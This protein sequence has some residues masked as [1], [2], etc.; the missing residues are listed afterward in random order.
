[1]RAGAQSRTKGSVPSFTPVQSGL[2][3]RKCACG[4]APGAD[5]EC[6][7]CKENRLQ[8]KVASARQ[9][10]AVPPLMHEVLRSP[11]R[12]LDEGTR[13]FLEPRFGHDFG[14]VRVHTDV[15]AAK[16][17]SA[18][19][20]LAYTVGQDVVFGAGRYEP[21][22]NEGRRLIAHE[23]THTLQ[24]RSGSQLSAS[25]VINEPGDRYEREADRISNWAVDG[26]RAAG[27]A[28]IPVIQAPPSPGPA[29]LARA[30]SSAMKS[31]LLKAGQPLTK[32]DKENATREAQ[33][34]PPTGTLKAFAEGPTFVLHDTAASSSAQRLQELQGLGRRSSGE[35]A[36]AYVP[37]DAPPV[38]AH[39]SLFSQR[40]PAATQYERIEDKLKQPDREKSYG[41]V[42]KATNP[43]YREAALDAVLAAQGS[44]PKEA[45][46]LRKEAIAQL[47]AGSGVRS[48]G[49]WAVED[50]CDVVAL[51]S[52]LPLV[53][54]AVFLAAS[55][56]TLADLEAACQDLSPVHKARKDR[57]SSSTNVE[58]VQP[59]GSDCWTTDAQVR[60]FNNKQVK[61]EKRIPG[62]AL[63]PLPTPPYSD[64][65]YQG[66]KRLYLQAALVAGQ[67][68][69]ITTHFKI[70]KKIGDH[71]DP[72]CFNLG[73]LYD[74]IRTALSHPEGAIY[75][76]IPNYDRG[77]GQNVWWVDRVCG[78]A[79]P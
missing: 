34:T 67:F 43:T 16:S 44:S 36:A 6:S 5:G 70:D 64:N 54:A 28:E 32:E 4:G 35:G 24:Q 71:C 56:V 58:M 49:A 39:P 31:D 9:A 29:L 51:L 38:L 65:Q 72:R 69:Q 23:L 77:E 62:D 60:A 20:A 21:A 30:L 76:V 74:L 25:L 53:D 48:A 10:Q 18:V 8:R 37:R 19:G 75:G 57:I 68:P 27:E 61:P 40:R 2:L 50:I 7:E 63:V 55:P 59:R 47:N 42:W 13:N 1:M 46:D 79:H 66:V 12:P 45:K 15:Q 17:A 22:T 78:G 11:G 3:Q 14:R 73:H 52:S 41:R 26:P 33:A